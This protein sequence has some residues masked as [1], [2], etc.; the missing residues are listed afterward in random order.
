MKIIITKEQSLFLKRRIQE[1]S[2][3]VKLALQEVS[4]DEYKLFDYIEEICWQVVDKY[5]QNFPGNI[6]EIFNYVKVNY[7]KE[8]KNHY[9]SE[10]N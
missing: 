8:I 6:D 7:S 1:I 5:K 2:E 10:T 3:F 4:P 9:L